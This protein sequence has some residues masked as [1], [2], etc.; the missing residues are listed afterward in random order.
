MYL[1]LFEILE[2]P[3]SESIIGFV[4]AANKLMEFVTFSLLYNTVIDNVI[5]NYN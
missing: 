4:A 3:T 2:L 5:L 1:I